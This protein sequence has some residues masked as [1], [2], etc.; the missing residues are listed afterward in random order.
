T[1]YNTY[2]FSRGNEGD[3][4]KG[5]VG[6]TA[7]AHKDGR[8]D[9]CG[10]QEYINREYFGKEENQP[11][12]KT[13]NQGLEFIETNKD[14]DNWYLQIEAFDPH[15]PFFSQKKYREMYPK[16]GYQGPEFDWPGYHP[17]NES[18]TEIAE[19]RKNYFALLTQCDTY[20]GKVLDTMD[21]YNLWE[22]TMLIV[23]T[24]HG[25]LLSEHEWWGKINMPYWNEIA[26]TPFYLYSPKDKNFPKRSEK[27]AQTIDIAP[28]L[29]DYFGLEATP[30]MEGRSLL[31]VLREEEEAKEYA[32]FGQF[33][34]YANITDGRYV[35]MRSPRKK[36]EELLPNFMLE[37][38]SYYNAVTVDVLKSRTEGRAF[39]FSKGVKIPLY[40]DGWFVTGLK[41]FP[42]E[43]IFDN[44]LLYDLETDPGQLHPIHDKEV[45][46]RMAKA[47][48]KMM[49]HN[50]APV[51]LYTRF[52]FV[53]DG[54]YP[55]KRN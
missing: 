27:L 21:K 52:G 39:S 44:D 47:M 35:Y 45:E 50:D 30:D 32:L 5:I 2:E 29:L 22:D 26:H 40:K 6:Y 18:E 23:N 19:C 9:Y 48:V 10:T 7:P 55:G 34:L 11:I 17:V 14:K 20:L 41:G 12:A 42:P 28:T 33:G 15:E 54:Y 25:F 36:Y 38:H 4:W 43:S 53:D 3:Q 37:P 13:F 31:R 8:R 24:D 1:K 49:E 51:E 46:D 16:T